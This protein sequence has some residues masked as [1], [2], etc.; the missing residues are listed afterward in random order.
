MLPGQPSGKSG[1]KRGASLQNYQITVLWKQLMLFNLP[2]QRHSKIE[3]NMIV[4]L[5]IKARN[6][7][8]VILLYFHIDS[9]VLASPSASPSHFLLHTKDP[10]IS[11]LSLCVLLTWISQNLFS[12]FSCTLCMCAFIH[13]RTSPDLQP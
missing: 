9:F 5:C 7:C 1:Q 8:Q 11:L 2:M 4:N 6:H 10:T 12:T 13:H 3:W